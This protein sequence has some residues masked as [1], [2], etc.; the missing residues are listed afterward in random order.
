M[1]IVSLRFPSS[2]TMISQ[3]KYKIIK[4]ESKPSL[5]L[6]YLSLDFFLISLYTSYLKRKN[7]D[8]L[9][10][11]GIECFVL[12]KMAMI[13]CEWENT[14]S[15][16]R[17]QF[18]VTPNYLLINITLALLTNDVR[19]CCVTWKVVSQIRQPDSYI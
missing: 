8:W 5:I 15:T 16:Q 18:Q 13:S 9:I 17:V 7:K 12:L 2:F 19:P 4:S 6:T 14:R 11:I 3:L 10:I 1:Q